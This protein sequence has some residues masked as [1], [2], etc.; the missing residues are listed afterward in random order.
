MALGGLMPLLRPEDSVCTRGALTAIDLGDRLH[1]PSAGAIARRDQVAVLCGTAAAK[2]RDQ[3]HR[4][5]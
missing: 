1:V 4:L 2:F 5:H 3:F